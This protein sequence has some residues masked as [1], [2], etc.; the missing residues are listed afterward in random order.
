MDCTIVVG[1][2]NVLWNIWEDDVSLI[3]VWRTGEAVVQCPNAMLQS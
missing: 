3:D 2:V 1:V